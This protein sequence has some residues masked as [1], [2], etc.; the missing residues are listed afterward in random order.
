[1]L[2]GYQ[3][4]QKN[5]R[6]HP[7]CITAMSSTHANSE[8]NG[9]HHRKSAI[10]IVLVVLAALY[11]LLRPTLNEYLGLDLPSITATAGQD[12]DLND[13][14]SLDGAETGVSDETREKAQRVQN[15]DPAQSGNTEQNQKAGET[16]PPP[17]RSSKSSRPTD[18]SSSKAGSDDRDSATDPLHGLLKEV[19]PKVY[20]SP[21]GLIYGPG[22][23][24]GHRLEHLRRHTK[25]DPGRA[26]SH[27]VFDG[28]MEGMLKTVDR[29][30]EYA[31]KGQ[32]TTTRQDKDR[33]IHTVD[34]GKRVGYVGGRD[35]GRRRKPMARRV[36]IVL[37]GKKVITAYPK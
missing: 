4:I 30:Y 36:T 10:A 14:D 6:R 26:G 34:M 16:E 31:K 24:E 32:R 21:A 29:A 3:L 12:N 35:G 8:P 25:D 37:E 28:G 9:R 19:S 2:V 7:L 23:R 13:R 20:L 22:S 11:G 17:E 1:M 15:S 33:T 18:D 5:T 27:G